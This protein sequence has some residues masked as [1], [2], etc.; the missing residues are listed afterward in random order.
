MGGVGGYYYDVFMGVDFVVDDVDVGYYFVVD[1]VNGVENYCVGRC[2][3]VV[4]RGWYL[5][6][7]FVE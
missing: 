3:G 1:V 2:F 7:Y 5:L 6:D 4:L